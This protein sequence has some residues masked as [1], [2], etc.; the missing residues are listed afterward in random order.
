MTGSLS[1]IRVLD[2]S[3]ILAGPWASQILADLGADVIKIERPGLGDD[4]R[5][6]G[7]PF[8]KDAD[9]DAKNAAYFGATN[10]N[11][12]SVTIDITTPEGQDLVRKLAAKSDIVLENYKVGGLAKYG[13]D[14]PNL[15]LIKPDIIYCSI[16]GFGQDGPYAT[17]AGYDALIQAMGGLMSITGQPDGTSGGGPMKVGVAVSDVL[18]GLYAAIGILAAL[19]HRER[20]GQGQYIDVSLLDVQVAALANQALNYLASGQAP[21]RCGNSHPNIVPYQAFRTQDG[22]VIIAVGNDEQF[23]RFCSLAGYPNL[24]EDT[25][26]QSN[27]DR[28]RNRETLVPQLEEIIAAKPT[29][30]WVAELEKASI[31]GG[32]INT[33]A[34]VFDDPQVRHRGMRIDIEDADGERAPGVACPI[35]LSE[36]PPEYR[37]PPPDLGADTDAVLDDV[38]GA[39]SSEIAAWRKAGII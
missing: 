27:A 1:H 3:R 24:A 4:T 8:L 36:T 25:R 33:I 10:R 17:R 39:D 19:A 23:A 7:P 32:P 26:Y 28:V 31:P 11:K 29:G 34:E 18:T 35:R 38:I 20:T 5:S 14:Y 6:W 21:V 15:R 9:T 12:K 16:T 30:W 37:A 22:H 13:L 2:M